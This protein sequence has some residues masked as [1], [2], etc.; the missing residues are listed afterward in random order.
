MSEVTFIFLFF[1]NLLQIPTKKLKILK[2]Q[3]SV[4]V[5]PQRKRWSQ[6]SKNKYHTIWT[7]MTSASFTNHPPPNVFPHV[8][9]FP[10]LGIE[11]GKIFHVLDEIGQ[12]KSFPNLKYLWLFFDTNVRDKCDRV[13]WEV[14]SVSLRISILTSSPPADKTILA[15]DTMMVATKENTGAII[16]QELYA[17]HTL[18]FWGVCAL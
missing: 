8:A 11:I 16:I 5:F 6:S 2:F 15:D 3:T 14:G 13:Q 17:V 18:L 9:C 12:K 7:I 10:L 4:E 1:R